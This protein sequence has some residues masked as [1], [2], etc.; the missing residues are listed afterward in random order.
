MTATVISADS[1]VL[2]R[3]AIAV[4]FFLLGFSRVWLRVNSSWRLFHRSC[5]TQ[6]KGLMYLMRWSCCFECPSSFSRNVYGYLW[7]VNVN[8]FLLMKCLP[9]SAIRIQIHNWLSSL[10]S[11]NIQDP[12]LSRNWFFF[13]LTLTERD[14]SLCLF[15]H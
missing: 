4:L 5:C 2:L 1:I 11:K 15:L 8:E 6:Q 10:E 14:S 9:F 7:I 12:G 13:M 3:S